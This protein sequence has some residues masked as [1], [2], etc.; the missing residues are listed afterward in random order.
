VRVT[1]EFSWQEIGTISVDAGR[2]RFPEAPATPG[3][4]T[5]DFGDR[6][7]VGEADQL[8]RRLQHY[9]TPGSSQRTNLRLNDFTLRLLQAGGSVTVRTVTNAVVEIDGVRATLDLRQKAARQLVENAAL[10]AASHSG[11]RVE[12][13]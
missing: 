9:R 13:L 5:F 11:G 6:V 1:V 8:R 2:L 10:T 3:I 12:N 4:Y 7:Y